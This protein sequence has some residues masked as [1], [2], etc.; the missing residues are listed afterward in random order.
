MPFGNPA[1]RKPSKKAYIRGNK[2]IAVTPIARVSRKPIR[3]EHPIKNKKEDVK[4]P[5]IKMKITWMITA[6][7]TK[8]GFHVKKSILIFIDSWLV[9][10]KNASMARR[11]DNR[12]MHP[13]KNMGNNSPPAGKLK[14][15]K[16]K[17]TDKQMNNND[18]K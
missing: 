16:P 4:Y 9:C 13:N 11:Q 2:T 1:F 14:L 10:F 18:V 7:D 5:K 15:S 17:N 12:I 3:I 6:I 8:S